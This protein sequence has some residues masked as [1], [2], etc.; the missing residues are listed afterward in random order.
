MADIDDSMAELKRIIKDFSTKQNELT[1]RINP[2]SEGIKEAW[3]KPSSGTASYVRKI[4]RKIAADMNDYG[5]SMSDT[6]KKYSAT[7]DIFEDS[8]LNLVVNP[9]VT[10]TPENVS[11]FSEYLDALETLKET[12][13][14]TKG[15]FTSLAD[16]ALS[17]KG[18]EKDI[19]RSALFIESETRTFVGL[20]DKSIS[21]LDRTI[22][23]GR[24]EIKKYNNKHC[25]N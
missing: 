8:I 15:K 21:T 22:A 18:I 25:Q 24:N 1:K 4:A 2:K 6:N 3:R 20:L 11:G 19:T 5:T 9:I 13:T 23:I 7:W 14:T 12:M 16:Q 17:L 10:K